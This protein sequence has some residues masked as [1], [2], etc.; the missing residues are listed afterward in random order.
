MEEG[1]GGGYRTDP[2][3]R[4]VGKTNQSATTLLHVAE[5]PAER[6]GGWHSAVEPLWAWDRSCPAVAVSPLSSCGPVAAR[7][8]Q[9]RTHRHCW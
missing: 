3:D 7:S 8:G 2:G 6:V 4:Q 5:R 9:C 1:R